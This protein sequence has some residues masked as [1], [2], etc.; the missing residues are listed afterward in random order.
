MQHFAMPTAGQ[1]HST[2]GRVSTLPTVFGSN[3]G[4]HK[5]EVYL[6]SRSGGGKELAR[7]GTNDWCVTRQ[8][9]GIQGN[10]GHLY[11]SSGVF[12]AESIGEEGY[13][14]RHSVT[15]AGDGNGVI[16]F[17]SRWQEAYKK[18]IFLL[19]VRVGEWDGQTE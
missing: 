3:V 9:L 14:E 4:N 2:A 8:S 5:A 16:K 7:F 12:V 18:S 19:P 10:Q 6:L 11:I 13:V 17:Q 1:P 15:H